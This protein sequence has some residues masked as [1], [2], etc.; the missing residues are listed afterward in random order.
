MYV[1]DSSTNMSGLSP[2]SSIQ[3]PFGVNHFAEVY[4]YMVPSVNLDVL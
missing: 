1:S 2:T 4:L 3:S